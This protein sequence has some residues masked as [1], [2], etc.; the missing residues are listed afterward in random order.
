MA[1]HQPAAEKHLVAAMHGLR[2]FG[3]SYQ[4]FQVTALLAGLRRCA[5]EIRLVQAGR[6]RVFDITLVPQL[7]LALKEQQNV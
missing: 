5:E 3:F 4:G 7:K 1:D 6:K 2:T